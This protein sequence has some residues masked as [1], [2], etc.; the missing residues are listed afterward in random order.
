MSPKP[1][2]SAERKQQILTAATRVFA[3]RGIEASRMQEI[4]REAGLSVGGVYWY[5]QSKEEI[6]LGL[7]QSFVEKDLELARSFLQTPGSARQR[8]ELILTV[9]LNEAVQLM[10][11]TLELYRESVH[12]AEVRALLQNYL[13]SYR[14][15]FMALIAHGISTGEFRPVDP[16]TAAIMLIALYEGSMELTLLTPDLSQAADMFSTNLSLFFQGIENA[17]MR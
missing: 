12:N 11:I 7:L 17:N 15:V 2:V 6:V 1:D 9:G 4:A 14:E 10:P 8:L 13:S 3:R 5:Y 16:S